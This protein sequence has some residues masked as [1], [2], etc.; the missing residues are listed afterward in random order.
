MYVLQSSGAV[1]APS[2]AVPSIGWP[3]F[4]GNNGSGGVV[5]SADRPKSAGIAG[6][7]PITGSSSGGGLMASLTGAGRPSSSTPAA[8]HSGS[9]WGAGV[10][11]TGVTQQQPTNMGGAAQPS[12]TISPYGSLKNRFLSGSTANKQSGAQ[13]VPVQQP[14]Q[15]SQQGM[16]AQMSGG[17]SANGTGSK[18]KLFSLAR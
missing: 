3:N 9:Q 11:A 2:S 15:Q 16:T 14:Q 10:S 18:S 6:A 4:S 13:Q 1:P 5:S 12:N 7:P 17:G 8:N